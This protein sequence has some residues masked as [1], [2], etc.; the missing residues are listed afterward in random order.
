MGSK[1]SFFLLN[2]EVKRLKEH[3]GKPN[4]KPSQMGKDTKSSSTTKRSSSHK[5]S[6]NSELSK[7]NE[8]VPLHDGHAKDIEQIRS[9]F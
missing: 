1:S 4:I 5:R 8:L 7:I 2:L 3:K 9:L 6:K